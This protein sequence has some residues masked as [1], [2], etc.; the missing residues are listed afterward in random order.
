MPR[1]PGLKRACC[2]A[3]SAAHAQT[4][5]GRPAA[6]SQQVSTSEFELAGQRN[7]KSLGKGDSLS[8]TPQPVP[9]HGDHCGCVPDAWP[10]KRNDRRQRRREQFCNIVTVLA[11]S[12]Q[13]QLPQGSLVCREVNHRSKRSA[14]TAAATAAGTIGAAVQAAAAVW[15]EGWEP[16]LAVATE[17]SSWPGRT[18]T[19]STGFGPQ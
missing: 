13:D 11:L 3:F 4:H 7:R 8:A 14:C 12:E 19:E 18:G 1:A 17:R 15:R 10:S 5:L 9:R 6:S 2:E 16:R